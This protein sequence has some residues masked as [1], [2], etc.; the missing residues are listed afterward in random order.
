MRGASLVSRPVSRILSSA[1]PVSPGP[2]P[3]AESCWPC[4]LPGSRRAGSSILLGVAPDGVWPA[5]ASPR[6]WCALTAPFH[7]CLFAPHVWARHRRSV[8]VPLSR[9]FRRVAYATVRALRC[10]DFPRESPPAAARLAPSSVGTPRTAQAREA[11]AIQRNRPH[12]SG[13]A[14]LSSEPQPAQGRPA[15]MLGAADGAGAAPLDDQALPGTERA[16]RLERRAVVEQA[17]GRRATRSRALGA[18]AR[19]ACRDGAHR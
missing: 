17:R 5:A 7:P 12:R 3:S 13:V 18:A 10:P 19:G 6:R 8:S 2:G 11:D 16:M 14:Q 1:D 15:I 9:G 4:P